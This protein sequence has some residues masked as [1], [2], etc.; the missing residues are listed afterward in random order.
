M[1]AGREMP[2]DEKFEHY[3]KIKRQADNALVASGLEWVI[4]RPGALTHQEGDGLVKANLAVPFGP[5]SRSN[6]ASML[7]AMIES[8]DICREIIELTDGDVP[9]QDAVRLLRR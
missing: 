6:V 5:V 9:I 1:D 7:A 8:P 4:L 2:K 3:M